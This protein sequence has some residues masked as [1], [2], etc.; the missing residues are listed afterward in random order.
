M[1]AP[2]SYESQNISY[3][4]IKEMK[5]SKGSVSQVSASIF[6]VY[7]KELLKEP[8]HETNRQIFPMNFSW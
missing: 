2:N 7:V 5:T 6:Q 4:K 3:W 8:G 1:E